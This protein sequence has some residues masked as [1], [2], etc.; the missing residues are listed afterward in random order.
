MVCVIIARLPLSLH[1]TLAQDE[2]SVSFGQSRLGVPKIW[3]VV[4]HVVACADKIRI[5]AEWRMLHGNERLGP[6]CCGDIGQHR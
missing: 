5:G 3:A 6:G 4:S 1:F 2:T